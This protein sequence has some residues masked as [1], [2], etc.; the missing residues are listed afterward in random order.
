MVSAHSISAKIVHFITVNING[1]EAHNN[2][3][4]RKHPLLF[5]MLEYINKCEKFNCRKG[6][7]LQSVMHL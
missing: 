6:N 4:L 5:T 2:T 3:F 1:P 7:A